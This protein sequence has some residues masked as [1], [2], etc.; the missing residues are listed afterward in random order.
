MDRYDDKTLVLL[1]CVLEYPTPYEHTNLEKIVTLKKEFPDLIIGYSYHTKP[2]SEYQVL[3]TAYNLGASIIEKHYTLNKALKG[4]D[5]YHAMDD[6]DA[7]KII[8]GIEFIEKIRGN[9]D[10]VC[11][12]SEKKAR[13][14]AR[15]SLVAAK[16]IKKG[17]KITS[18]MLTLK[19]P[20]TGINADRY[21]E[22]IGKLARVDICEDAVLQDDM[23]VE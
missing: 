7:K 10:L 20:G 9:G 5:H 2:D 17:E 12:D 16:D 19:R 18:D 6:V 4:N 21:A 23:I 1:H 13:E 11:L 15:R 8:E 14:N 22:I 3:K